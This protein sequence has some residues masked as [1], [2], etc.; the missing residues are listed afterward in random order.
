MS[1]STIA[2]NTALPYFPPC[3][4]ATIAPTRTV[5]GLV[6]PDLYSHMP[7]RF[8]SKEEAVQHR[9]KFFYQGRT[10]RNGHQAP[11]FVCNDRMCVDCHRAKRGKAPIG[12]R[13][14]AVRVVR[15][16]QNKPANGRAQ[17]A[18]TRNERKFLE[19]Y[20]DTRDMDKAASA[21][22][23]TRAKILARASYGEEFAAALKALE[24]RLLTSGGPEPEV[25][26]FAWTPE[27]RTRLIE[28][29]IDTGDIASAREAA[30]VSPSEFFRELERNAEFAAQ[31]KAAEP[32]A[33]KALEEK[34]VQLALRGNDKLLTKILAAKMPEQYRESLKLDVTQTGVMRLD[35][36][37]VNARIARLLRRFPVTIEHDASGPAGLIGIARGEGTETEAATPVLSV[38]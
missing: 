27:V 2:D 20:A 1:A 32:L 9:W 23:S 3:D 6:Y 38:P 16:A 12:L 7:S 5:R 31:L 13:S 15:T 35:D 10:C 24:A 11:V 22:R 19:V 17:S 26:T 37:Q 8:V 30:S 36:E 14:S 28:K 21:V 4:P 25:P 18:L 34:A 33:S 29:Y